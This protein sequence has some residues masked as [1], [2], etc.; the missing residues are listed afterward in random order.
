M[1]SAKVSVKADAA[2]LFFVC[3]CVFFFPLSLQEIRY[4]SIES[5]HLA[6]KSFSLGKTQH[7][8]FCFGF[9][10]SLF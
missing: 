3:V 9:V 4:W 6:G 8:H 1:S 10:Y 7:D 5:K 2:K